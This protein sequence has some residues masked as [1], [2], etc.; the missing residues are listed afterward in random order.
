[1]NRIIFPLDGMGIDKAAEWISVLRNHIAYFK[2]GLELFVREGHRV[3]RLK[4][5]FQVPIMLDLKFHDI[6]TTMEGA[7]RA[8]LSLGAELLTVH[9]SAGPDALEK[10]VRAVDGAATSIV[11]VTMLTSLDER[12][13]QHVF[14]TPPTGTLAIPSVVE[15]LAGEA[16]DAGVRHFVCSPYEADVI[17]GVHPGVTVITPGIRFKIGGDDQKRADTPGDAIANGA[18]LLVVGRTIRSALNPLHAIELINAKIEQ[19]LSAREDPM[20]R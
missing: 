5:D 3:A 10:C 7:T 14:R 18:D 16:V 11:A 4:R 15:R 8:A 13:V 12:F 2:V 20:N 17:K 1:M 9:A 6:P 19:G